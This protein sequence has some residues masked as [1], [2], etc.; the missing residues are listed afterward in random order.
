MTRARAERGRRRARAHARRATD[1]LPIPAHPYR[2]SAIFYGL[3]A[4]AVV[5]VA[6]GTGG[7]LLR[8]LVF[9]AAFFGIATAFSWWRFRAKLA[10]RA[11]A[12]EE[13]PHA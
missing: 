4:G 11:R 13:R 3:L 5:G 9:A 2:D 7:S 10:E 8:A 1:L 6:Y 12:D